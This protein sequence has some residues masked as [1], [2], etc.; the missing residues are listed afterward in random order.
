M[1]KEELDGAIGALEAW[2]RAVDNWMLICTGGAAF[3][4]IFLRGFSIA[5][6]G[7]ENRLRP[8]RT[9][10]AQAHEVEL[11]KLRSDTA[12]AQARAAEANQKTEEERLA[13]V[14]IEEY[15]APRAILQDQGERIV[16]KVKPFAGTPFDVAVDPAVEAGLPETLINMLGLGAGWKWQKHASANTVFPPGLEYSLHGEDCRYGTMGPE[17]PIFRLRRQL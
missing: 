17:T 15:F 9:A 13:R 12:D 7:N 16:E 2:G 4:A 10:Q 5:H 1:G 11:E 14:K 3:A 6:W 8:L